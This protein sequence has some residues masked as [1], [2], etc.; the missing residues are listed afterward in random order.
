[1]KTNYDENDLRSL[2]AIIDWRELEHTGLYMAHVRYSDGI[3]ESLLLTQSEW[4]NLKQRE[5][6]A[7]IRKA[8]AELEH[9]P[10]PL[11][12]LH[13]CAWCESLF[14]DGGTVLRKL[15]HEEFAATRT[16][17]S[18]YG[19]SHG[20]CT[21]CADK[22][23]AELR[24]SKEPVKP[25][26]AMARVARFFRSRLGFIGSLF[27]IS[28]ALVVLSGCSRNPLGPSERKHQIDVTHKHSDVD[29]TV[30]KESM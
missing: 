26:T 17:G 21:A 24:A 4:D 18:P 7:G 3:E 16:A 25:T 8:E 14:I 10:R 27:L 11:I 20:I 23:K 30:Y 2:D 5:L 13:V 15:S 28:V 1:M 22:Q 6:E 29:T 9:S 12:T 19:D